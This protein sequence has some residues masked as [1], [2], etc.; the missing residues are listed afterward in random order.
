MDKDELQEV[1]NKVYNAAPPLDSKKQTR[2]LEKRI[3][4]ATTGIINQWNK[5]PERV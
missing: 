2:L 3:D 5:L 4:N 1:L